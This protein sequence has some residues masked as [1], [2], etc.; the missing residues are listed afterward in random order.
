MSPGP[1][2]ACG[3]P[4]N[5]ATSVHEALLQALNELGEGV[6]FLEGERIVYANE[7]AVRMTGYTVSELLAL[8]S[9]A[10]L[11]EPPER[12]RARQ[13]LQQRLQGEPAPQHYEHAI[14]RKDGRR[15]ELEVAAQ[16]VQV[17]QGWQ[18]VAIYRDI[19]ERKALAQR[20]EQ[21]ALYD[22]LTQLPNRTLLHDRLQQAIAA[23]QR[24]FPFALLVLD[25]D[26]FKQINDTFG[27]HAGDLVLQQLARRLRGILRDTDTIARLGGDEFAILLPNARQAAAVAV[28][29][30]LCE[31]LAL[32]M[33]IEGRSPR[34][35]QA[36]Q[37]RASVGIALAPE[38]GTEAERL[39]RR[40]DR[41]MYQAKRRGCGYALP[42]RDGHHAAPESSPPD[43]NPSPQ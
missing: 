21:L 40:A 38:D 25:L 5:D 32:P 17:G 43:R 9:F 3:P 8:P 16:L 6:L 34:G 36:L 42:D 22:P 28:A 10:T 4:P 35:A 31:A 18:V 37:V 39:L 30:K 2:E 12:E 23:C 24:G 27:H 11:L 14:I 13:R 29:R 7:A 15:V 19:T 26:G 20:L 33:P 41:A 1:G